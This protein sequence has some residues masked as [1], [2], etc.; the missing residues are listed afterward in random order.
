ML[1][2]LVAEEAR[3]QPEKGRELLLLAVRPAL[4]REFTRELRWAAMF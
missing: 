3:Q 4:S 1:S 2:P